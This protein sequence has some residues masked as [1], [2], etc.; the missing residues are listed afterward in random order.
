MLRIRTGHLHGGIG[1]RED[2][3]WQAR[4]KNLLPFNAQLYDTPKGKAGKEYTNE[5]ANI[6]ESVMKRECN[7]EQL[8]VF[9]LW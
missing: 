2:T 8:M 7:S 5:I 9:M 3:L 1:A 4:H 6:L